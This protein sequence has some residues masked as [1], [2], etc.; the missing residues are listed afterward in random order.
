MYVQLVP[1]TGETLLT[2]PREVREKENL[3]VLDNPQPFEDDQTT[4]MLVLDI[5][6]SVIVTD[7]VV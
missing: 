2:D 7:I 1:L 5:V 6:R 4:R 3:V